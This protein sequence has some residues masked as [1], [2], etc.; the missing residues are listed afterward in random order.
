MKKS[1]TIITSFGT[2]QWRNKWDQLHRDGD[3]PALTFTDG[4]KS[5][6]I[7]GIR[8]RDNNLPACMWNNGDQSW[9]KNGVCY[10]WD[11]WILGCDE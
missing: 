4:S 7:N 9:W 8:H 11:K 10:R 6:Y 5:W 1:Y 2:Q 3:L